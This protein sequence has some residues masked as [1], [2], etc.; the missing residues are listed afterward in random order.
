MQRFKDLTS[1]SLAIKG[2]GSVES[3]PD[4][5]RERI[6]ISKRGAQARTSAKRGICF[7]IPTLY[8]C[9]KWQSVWNLKRMRANLHLSQV[10]HNPWKRCEILHAWGH[11]VKGKVSHLSVINHC[12]HPLWNYAPL[13][14]YFCLVLW[15]PAGRMWYYVET[16]YVWEKWR[17][18]ICV[19]R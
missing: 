15:C 4:T 1:S 7:R 9:S 12:L 3:Y 17:I 13:V 19:V 18:S 8:R 16:S 5:T 2:F 10:S 11:C 6:E 14:Y